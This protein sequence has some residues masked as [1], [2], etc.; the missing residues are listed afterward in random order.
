[1][2]EAYS[3]LSKIPAE[4]LLTRF[5]GLFF[6][7]FQ[8]NQVWGNLIS[9]LGLFL[10]CGVHWRNTSKERP[11]TAKSGIIHDHSVKSEL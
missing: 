7:I 8:M 4:A 10:V 11:V 9:S 3:K 1:V 2:S 5:F 6:M